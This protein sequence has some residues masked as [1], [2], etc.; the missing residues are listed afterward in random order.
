MNILVIAAHPDDEVLG[1]GGAIIKH[2]KEGDKVCI[3]IL[4]DGTKTRYPKSMA[5][6]LKKEALK[7]AKMLG[8]SKVIFKSLPNQLLDTV[9]ITDV[10]K[11]IEKV[12][13]ETKPDIVYTHAK[14]DLNRDHRLV[15]E[16]TLVATRPI[17]GNKIKKVLSYFV[18][19]SSEHND[20]EQENQFIPNVFLNIKN[21]IDIKIKA[22]SCYRT[23]IRPYPHPR[24]PEAMRVYA[25]YWGIR[26]G[27]EYAEPFRLIREIES[28]I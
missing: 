7:C 21:E 17:P 25:K 5:K 1:C 20:T 18:P 19:S 12:I 14:N 13:D 27:I 6:Q 8:I 9:A 23:E 26:V 15:Y 2:A 10:I 22:V 11:T 16:A 3:C 28:K 24:S 4:T